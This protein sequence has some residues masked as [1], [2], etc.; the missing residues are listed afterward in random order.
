M[1]VE[2]EQKGVDKE[3]VKVLRRNQYHVQYKNRK[4]KWKS[5]KEPVRSITHGYQELENASKKHSKTRLVNV[6]DIGAIVVTIS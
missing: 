6:T 4:G 2:I 1:L 5:Y 3:G